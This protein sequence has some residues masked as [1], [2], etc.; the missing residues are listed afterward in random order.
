VG[1]P[2]E[3]DFTAGENPGP[4]KIQFWPVVVFIE[5]RRPKG[6]HRVLPFRGEQRKIARFQASKANGNA[7]QREPAPG[8]EHRSERP[9][10]SFVSYGAETKRY[11]DSSSRKSLTMMSLMMSLQ[12]FSLGSKTS[13]CRAAASALRISVRDGC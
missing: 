13:S 7:R 2:V 12:L 10:A 8:T 6:L 9:G 4:A 5:I 1:M 11:E 3:A